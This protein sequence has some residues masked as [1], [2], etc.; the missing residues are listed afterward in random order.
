MPDRRALQAED[1]LELRFVGDPQ[2]SPDGSRVVFVLTEFDLNN[3]GYYSSLWM[4]DADDPS[5]VRPLTRPR[6]TDAAV[7]D[8][9]PR[10]CPDGGSIAFISNRAGE[11][12][13]YRIDTGG[14][15]AQPV[16]DFSGNIASIAWSPDGEHIAFSAEPDGEADGDDKGKADVYAT[17]RLKHKLNGRGFMR[18]QRRYQIWVTGV[19]D[20]ETQQLTDHANDQNEPTWSPDGDR[21]FF[22]A[23]RRCELE[24][25]YVPDLYCVDMS[26]GSVRR[27]TEGAGP[28]TLPRISPDGEVVAFFGHD[29]G[30]SMTA[31]TQL[32][33]ISPA[34]QEFRSLTADFDRSVGNS[35][36]GDA[37]FDEGEGGPAWCR[38]GASILFSLTDG[39]NC[40]LYET[41]RAGGVCDLRGFPPVITS[42]SVNAAGDPTIAAVGADY[43]NPGDLWVKKAS[44][45][46]VRFTDFNDEILDQIQLARPERFT[47]AGTDDWEMEGWLLRPTEYCEGE[48][49]PLILEIHGGPAATSGNAFMHQYQLLA[50]SGFGVL[51]TNPRGSKGYG[52]EHAA[53]VIGDWGGNDYRDLMA[54][55]DAACAF[56]W[57]DEKRLGVTG[58]SYGGFM[59]NW[60]VSQTD[61]FAAAVTFRSISNLYTKYGCSDIGFY[62][63]RRGM[64]GAD[65]WEEEE[66]IMSR[67]PMRHAPNVQTPTL[68]VH[69]EEDLRC[70]ME[71]AE[72]W[73]VA[74][75]R[76]GV[77]CEFVRYSGENHELSR[78][79]KPHNRMDRL[80]RLTDWFAAYLNREGR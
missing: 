76:L 7:R 36:M 2:V 26:D 65:L 27:I 64:G 73:F 31:N 67:S 66:F 57:V 56:D 19:R 32:S 43:D 71:Q 37:R 78:S 69:A 51:Y 62:S 17:R 22:T 6:R 38:G 4:A 55:V 44:G 53:G 40:G 50:A 52:E 1:L 74:L 72:Q 47:F 42:Y 23:D 29:K 13:I 45:D 48:K 10:W 35:V 75:K 18:D 54:A 34:G 3:N 77:E 11:R 20:G 58:G 63:N 25:Y 16:G 59:T 79:G 14:G 5:S 41:D 9:S 24:M 49:Y 28:V 21:L 30:D 39:G 33:L 61:R 80:H 12:R 60:I 8:T 15:E 68:I 46:P 70:P